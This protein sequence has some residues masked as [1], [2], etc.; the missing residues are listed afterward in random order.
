MFYDSE[1]NSDDFKTESKHFFFFLIIEYIDCP[2]KDCNDSS[3]KYLF[4]GERFFKSNEY[5]I[6]YEIN[7]IWIQFL[8]CT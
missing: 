4:S 5:L 7:Q 6:K 3:I 1:C 8:V 2:I